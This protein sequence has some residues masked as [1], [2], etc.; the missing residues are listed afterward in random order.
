M[1]SL[2]FP[3]IAVPH[4]DYRSCVTGSSHGPADR[5]SHVYQAAADQPDNRA[6]DDRLA[7][8]YQR[9]NVAPISV[10]LDATPTD[11]FSR[12]YSC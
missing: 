10:S 4:A 2:P 9:I 11:Q 6:D 8:A 1:K 12:Y 5:I 3:G 7:M